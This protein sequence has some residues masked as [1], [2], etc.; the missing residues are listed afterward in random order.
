MEPVREPERRS[1]G[2]TTEL[3][4]GLM[5][6][7]GM[8]VC[9]ERLRGGVHVSQARARIDDLRG[10]AHRRRV[11]D[12]ARAVR[13]RA[14]LLRQDVG[15]ERVRGS[16]AD[17]DARQM[18]HLVQSTPWHSARACTT[19]PLPT[20]RRSSCGARPARSSTSPSTSAGVADVQSVVR[21]RALGREPARAVRSGGL[22]ARLSHARGRHGGPLPDVGVP[23]PGR[24]ARRALGRP[25]IRDRM[26]GR[27]RGDQRP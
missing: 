26:A 2:S 27:G 22:C 15:C 13:G 9:A 11:G 1:T 21:R 23:R 3:F 25:R 24:R 19:R 18:Q 10:D 7:R 12:R 17:R 14:R 5:R 8:E 20:R 4:R 16:G 6:V